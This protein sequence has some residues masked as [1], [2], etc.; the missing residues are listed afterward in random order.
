MSD[1]IKKAVSEFEVIA[2]ATEEA[3]NEWSGEGCLQFPALLATM[4]VKFNWEEQEVRKNDPL[5]R[6]YIRQ[7]ADWHVTRGA[8]GGIMRM[9]EKQKKEQ[10]KVA[11]NAAKEA[12]RAAVEAK[13]DAPATD[14]VV[15]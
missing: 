11:K 3:L 14:S 12:A 15:E 1:N 6:F 8:H 10:S 5:V 13:S 2:K 4:A 7:H 9:S